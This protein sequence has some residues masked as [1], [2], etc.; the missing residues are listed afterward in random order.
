[1]YSK[2]RRISAFSGLLP[3]KRRPREA[4]LAGDWPGLGLRVAA[5][6]AAGLDKLGSIIERR[7]AGS[8]IPD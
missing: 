8:A 5:E 7:R 6:P 2:P 3:V 4:G 1:E